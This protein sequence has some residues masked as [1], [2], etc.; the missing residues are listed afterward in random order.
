MINV[1]ARSPQAN[2][3]TAGSAAHAVDLVPRG[4]RITAA[5]QGRGATGSPLLESNSQPAP[6][7]DVQAVAAA[8]RKAA[9]G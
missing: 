4:W 6:A 8:G 9:I 1:K 3:Q 5:A 2:L 7:I